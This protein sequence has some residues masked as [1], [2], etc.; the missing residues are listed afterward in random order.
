MLRQ[1][2]PPPPADQSRRSVRGSGRGSQRHRVKAKAPT[3][4]V[5]R[6]LRAAK[7]RG[8]HP[9]LGSH[10][11]TV[12]DAAIDARLDGSKREPLPPDRRDQV[13]DASVVL[14]LLPAES[15][16]GVEGHT[17]TAR[18]LLPRHTLVTLGDGAMDADRRLAGVRF[19]L[20]EE[21]RGQDATSSHHRKQ[22]T[23]RPIRP[24]SAAVREAS[25]RFVSPSPESTRHAS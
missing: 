11:M 17:Q 20:V 25:P 22:T 14:V 6:V 4:V 3:Q 5:A 7:P 1:H 10:D 8:L 24:Q 16:G 13:V 2:P 18:A 21:W 9:V 15:G 23:R 12:T 19:P